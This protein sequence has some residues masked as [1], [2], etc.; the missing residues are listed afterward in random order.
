MA[1][2]SDRKYIEIIRQALWSGGSSLIP[3][4]SEGTVGRA[5]VMIGS[6]FS[7]NATPL[8]ENARRFPLWRDLVNLMIDSLMPSPDFSDEDRRNRLNTSVAISGAL[9][10]AEE[11]EATFGRIKL[12]ELLVNAIPD[13]QNEPSYLHRLLL[14]LPWAD[15]LT[16]NY[17]T[18]L[19]RDAPLNYDTVIR[20]EDIP[21]VTR[22]RIV[23][24]HGSFPSSRP[25]IFTE[26]DFRTY[27]QKFAPLINLAQQTMI[28]NIVCVIGF[29]GDDP[30]F[31][32][33]SGWV[34]DHLGNAA[35]RIY[36]VG[37]MDYSDS[38]RRVLEQRNV[39]VVDLAPLFSPKDF[40]DASDRH[41]LAIE[42]F[43][44][45]LE[46]GKPTAPE[47][48]PSSSPTDLTPPTDSR[49]PDRFEPAFRHVINEPSQPQK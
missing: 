42:W 19:E 34:R 46:A 40:P 6:G 11:F 7:L 3:D 33:W 30:N 31:L 2:F 29:S 12:D 1:Q 43:L 25:F 37:V 36:L 9:R 21:L 47:D 32:H 28:E 38:Q 10:L 39:T 27:P 26:E 44:L 14:S 24:L 49:I 20:V 22:P 17:D 41:R 35:P 18:L 45:C 8:H 13:S 15:I 16:T 48:W 5:A 4:P 23:K